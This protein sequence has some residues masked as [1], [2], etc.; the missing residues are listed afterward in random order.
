[1]C[2]ARKKNKKEKYSASHGIN[3]QTGRTFK[4]LKNEKHQK[5]MDIKKEDQHDNMS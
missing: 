1:L 3:I 4:P 2:I 5:I